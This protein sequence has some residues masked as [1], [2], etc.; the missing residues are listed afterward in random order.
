MN[1]TPTPA[2]PRASA[3]AGA[4][5]TPTSAELRRWRQYLA[6]ER[7]EAQVYR[8]LAQRRTGSER[9]ILEAL[10]EA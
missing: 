3:T 4:T 5:A 9:E 10:A 8:E 6:D 1:D 7:A 2:A